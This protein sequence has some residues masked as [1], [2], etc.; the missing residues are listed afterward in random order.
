MAGQYEVRITNNTNAQVLTP[1]LVVVHNPGFQ[2]FMVGGVPT[3][4]LKAIAET[5]NSAKLAEELSAQQAVKRTIKGEAAIMPGQTISLSINAKPWEQLSVMGM[6]ATTNDGVY[7]AQGMQLYNYSSTAEANAYDAGSEANTERCDDIPGPPCGGASNH[8]VIN[9]AE[10]FITLHRGFHGVNEDQGD[11][12]SPN[13]EG[14]A[15]RHW[16]WRGPAATV[17]VKRED[18][19]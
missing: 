3:P 16:D 9:G 8:E 5:G 18:T 13:G 17:R 14:L 11:T 1:P 19:W 4:G 12:G 7:A 15:A 10:G 6:L 2:I